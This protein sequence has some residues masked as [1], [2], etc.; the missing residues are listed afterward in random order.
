ME[1]STRGNSTW[2]NYMEE[3]GISSTKEISFK[4]SL[5]K[6]NS[7][8]FNLWW[9][10]RKLKYQNQ[11]FYQ[12]VREILIIIINQIFNILHRGMVMVTIFIRLI[13]LI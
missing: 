4:D 9:S 11:L 5:K 7:Y 3:G 6:G 1:I 10:S 12:A 2:M 8:L 13:Q